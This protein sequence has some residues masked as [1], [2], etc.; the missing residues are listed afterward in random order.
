[1][2]AKEST[3]LDHNSES[4][5]IERDFEEYTQLAEGPG[6]GWWGPPK[7]THGPGSQGGADAD[8]PAAHLESHTTAA[9][10]FE[11]EY[12][13]SDLHKAAVPSG[14]RK[15]TKRY[16]TPGD[17]RKKFHSTLGKLGFEKYDDPMKT[18]HVASYRARHIRAH[19]D[20]S[21]GNTYVDFINKKESSKLRRG[22]A[23][24]HYD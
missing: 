8:K 18:K 1:M 17:K 11:K 3:Q 21:Q 7:G 13:G 22:P 15:F 23:Y 5:T 9:N 2:P 24:V 19:V 12:G 4:P 20:F 16:R 10:A 6:S 14:H